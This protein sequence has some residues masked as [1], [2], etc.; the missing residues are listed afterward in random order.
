MGFKLPSFNLFKGKSGQAAPARPTTKLG[1]NTTRV[2]KGLQEM[3]GDSGQPLPLIGEKP[4]KQ[5]LKIL[6]GAWAVAVFFSFT[7][8]IW[9]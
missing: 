6:G 2:I 7:P 4:L 1:L 8:L 9:Y 3:A 5:Q